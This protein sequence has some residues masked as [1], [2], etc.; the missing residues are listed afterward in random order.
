MKVIV[1][2][3]KVIVFERRESTT[4]CDILIESAKVEQVKEFVY[5]DSVFTNDGKHDKDIE[6][7]VN[8]G[9]SYRSITASDPATAEG[10][11]SS[12]G[13]HDVDAALGTPA[14]D[15]GGSVRIDPPLGTDDAGLCVLEV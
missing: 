11:G 1:G 12:S 13:D 14:L 5:L 2:R 6:K 9:R 4:E 15:A 3:T 7:G 8:A 10:D